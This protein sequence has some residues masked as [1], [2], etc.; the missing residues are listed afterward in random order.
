MNT[1]NKNSG[2]IKILETSNQDK[3]FCKLKNKIGIVLDDTYFPG[4]LNSKD[5]DYIMNNIY[6]NWNSNTFFDYLKTFEINENK[7]INECSKGMKMKLS[8]AVALSHNAKILILDEPTSGLD[9]MARSEMLN[10]FNE[11]T[12]DEENTILFSSH[13]ISDIEK[14]ADYIVFLNEGNLIFNEEKDEILNKYAITMVTG[15]QLKDI[16]ERAII[17]IEKQTYGYKLLVLKQEISKH[18]KLEN[19]TLEEIIVL[20]AK[21]GKR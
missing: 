5:I 7:M 8:I 6:K 3:E 13:I 12:R 20:L 11:F 15:E 1:I 16:P 10:I 4:K 17:H 21:E 14:V 9:P 2:T 19:S 18:F